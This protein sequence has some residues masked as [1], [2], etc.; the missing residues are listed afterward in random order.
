MFQRPIPLLLFTCLL[1]ID[2]QAPQGLPYYFSDFFQ[3]Y[4]FHYWRQDIFYLTC[5]IFPRLN[6]VQLSR[7]CGQNFGSKVYNYKKMTYV[8]HFPHIIPGTIVDAS[9]IF[10]SWVLKSQ[11]WHSSVSHMQTPNC[12]WSTLHVFPQ[13]HLHK[14]Y[15]YLSDYMLPLVQARFFQLLTCHACLNVSG[16]HR[17]IYLNVWF[18]IGGLFSKDQEMLPC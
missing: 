8:S 10:S 7:H 12:L 17:L 4:D 6:C 11:H 2:S 14:I 1:M 13:D 5:C 15:I 16:P 3:Q 18:P 9:K